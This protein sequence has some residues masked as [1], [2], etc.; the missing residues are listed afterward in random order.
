MAL[1]EVL[2]GK[3]VSE[4][5]W[6]DE[7]SAFQLGK[8]KVDKVPPNRLA[9]LARNG[10]SHPADRAGLLC[11]DEPGYMELDRRGAELLTSNGTIIQTGT[12]SYRLA[13][14]KAQAEQAQ[15]VSGCADEPCVQD[16]SCQP[17]D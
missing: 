2:E 15:A 7:S 4:L 3:R 9:A 6:V 5:E 1:L 12:E 11:I 14:I 16:G 10:K 17:S 13:H 8:V